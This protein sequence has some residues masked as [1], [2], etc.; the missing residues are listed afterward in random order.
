MY[1]QGLNSIRNRFA[2]MMG[3]FS[4]FICVLL[5]VLDRQTD[6]AELG[7]TVWIAIAL[8]ILFPMSM[9]YFVTGKLTGT[10]EALR[11]STEAVA[12]GDY[13]THV[14]VDCACE[15]GGLA[16]SF[17]TMVDR[18]NSNILKINVLAYTDAVTKLPNRAVLRHLLEF[19]LAR[20]RGKGRLTG[21]LLFID[22]DNFKLVNDTLGH[23]AGDELLR[24]ASARIL[25]EAF[26]VQSGD[27]E[28]C[29][30]AL[31]ELCAVVPDKLVFVRFAGDEFVALMPGV[32]DP[33]LLAHFGE[34]IVKTLK[35]PFIIKD[36]ECRIGASVGVAI[37]HKDSACPSEIITCADLAMYAAKQ[38]GRN[39]VAFYTPEMGQNAIERTRT[40]TELRSAIGRGE[41]RIMFQ[42]K[43]DTET[44]AVT[45]VEALVRWQHPERGMLDPCHFIGVAEQTGLVNA[46]GYEVLRLAAIQCREWLD[47]GIR[48]RISVNVC[49]TEFHRAD[50]AERVLKLISDHGMPYDLLEIE[51][52]ESVALAYPELAIRHLNML[53]DVGISIAID[54]FGV[55]YSNLSQLAALPFDTLK[56]DRS[57]VM[58][59]GADEKREQII[60]AII[61]MGNAMGHNTVAEGVET[62]RQFEFL[63]DQNCNSVQGYLLARPM[64]AEKL[65]RWERNHLTPWKNPSKRLSRPND[66]AARV[67]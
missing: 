50:F 8:A 55:G 40:E 35:R 10:I 56:I 37:L 24:V 38:G 13:N 9:T 4:I 59:I 16:D 62:I 23:E 18:L 64:E 41:L 6:I 47:Q 61:K 22:L 5:Y 46:L 43:V 28:H 12:R 15:V 2:L 3:A 58:G 25:D 27:V 20:E 14:E 30:S 11:L 19:G 63:A 57:L 21:G 60:T 32:S 7:P 33:A 51:V 29:T 1:G 65:I 39:R 44:L 31:G 45:S 36:S 42:P 26:G 49:H 66:M 54:D 67:A 48:R 34:R 17:R 52:T 53:R